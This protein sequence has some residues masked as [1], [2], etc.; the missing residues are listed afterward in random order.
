VVKVY[1]HWKIGNIGYIVELQLL[2]RQ[3]IGNTI[4]NNRQQSATAEPK[5]GLPLGEIRIGAPLADQNRRV[6]C[7]THS[8]FRVRSGKLRSSRQQ[9]LP[10]S[11]LDGHQQGIQN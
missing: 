7:A 8:D 10:L 4:G 11:R 5:L 9:R 3:Q 2:K 1:K 6:A